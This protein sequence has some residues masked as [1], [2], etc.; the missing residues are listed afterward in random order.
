MLCAHRFREFHE[1][2]WFIGT[3]CFYLQPHFSCTIVHTHTHSLWIQFCFGSFHGLIFLCVSSFFAIV[4][5][6]TSTE[7]LRYTETWSIYFNAYRFKEKAIS[8]RKL[9]GNRERKTCA[10]YFSAF[11]AICKLYSTQSHI[12][13]SALFTPNDRLRR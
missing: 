1:C 12:C 6:L 7:L 4:S 10:V 13:T 11:F 8:W 5:Y 3:D 2:Q 9:N